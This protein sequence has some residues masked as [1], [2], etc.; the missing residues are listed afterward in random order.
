MVPVALRG[1][2]KVIL[3]AIYMPSW[4]TIERYMADD[5]STGPFERRVPGSEMRS[6]HQ[7]DADVLTF[8]SLSPTDVVRRVACVPDHRLCVHVRPPRVSVRHGGR[9]CSSP[10]GRRRAILGIRGGMV[11][12]NASMNPRFTLPRHLAQA[13][14][15][16]RARGKYYAVAN[17]GVYEG[18]SVSVGHANVLV[19]CLR[20][21]AVERYCPAGRGGPLGDAL[22]AVIETRFRGAL[23]GWRYVG[24]RVSV[25][26]GVQELVDAYSGMCVTFCFMYTLLRL[27]NPTKSSRSIQVYMARGT[28]DDVR[29]RVLRL[30]RYMMD[31]LRAR[32]YG[33]LTR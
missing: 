28:V 6:Y 3:V 16:C 24:T 23:P 25:S 11:V 4:V 18:R 33:E 10:R 1:L 5:E 26:V 19:F 2:P 7:A 31:A 15:R 17:L 12:M 13:L 14:E 22:D 30:N 21:Q 32:R 8:L 29:S 27:L 20:E 9:R